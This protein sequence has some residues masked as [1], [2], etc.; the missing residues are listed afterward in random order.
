MSKSPAPKRVVAFGELLLRLGAP[1]RELLLQRPHLE[2]FYGG[3]EANVLIALAQLGHEA[4]MV[5]V[6]ADNAL[7]RAVVGELRRY[8]V[9]T[10]GVRAAEGRMGLYFLTTGAIARASDIIYDRADSAFARAA[11]D[12]IDWDE[13][14]VGADWLHL[15]GIT[16]AL[17]PNSAEA[18]VRAAES[19]RRLG[20]GVSVDCNYRPK[21]WEAWRGDAPAIMAKLLAQ[22]DV[23]FGD[24]RD[25]ELILKRSFAGDR[26]SAADALFAAF[27]NLRRIACTIREQVN[28]D[29]HILSALMFGPDG[30]W[31]TD[32]ETVTPIVD[33]IGGGD[34]FAA[35][36]LCGL[37]EEMGD[38]PSLDFALASTVLKHTIPGDFSLATRNEIV[39]LMSGRSL[40]VRR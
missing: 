36:L 40:D 33:R 19:A 6:V 39:N 32:K 5:S 26:R 18:V 7:G 14:L 22:A 29:H 3:A 38:Q 9:D 11:A 24:Y 16:A 2:V 20:V 21:L 10:R 1:G 30:Q 23:A 12:L 4:A 13:A 28:V 37:F 34:A 35:G 8:G 27:P 15:S 31:A 17:G 25:A